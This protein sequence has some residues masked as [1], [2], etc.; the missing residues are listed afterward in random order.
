MPLPITFGAASARGFGLFTPVGG[1]GPA[2]WMGVVSNST[3]FIEARSV[4][5]DSVGNIYIVGT[6]QVTAFYYQLIKLNKF[7]VIQWQKRLGATSTTCFNYGM[8]LDPSN[9]VYVCGYITSSNTDVGVAKYNGSGVLQWQVGLTGGAIGY[10]IAYNTSNATLYCCGIAGSFAL[11]FQINTSGTVLWSKRYGNTSGGATFYFKGVAASAT[12][13]SNAVG[14]Y[15]SAP[16]NYITFIQTDS[17]G[18]SQWTN[19]SVRQNND[20]AYA[21]TLDG[22]SNLYI[23]GYSRYLSDDIY[24][25]KCNS[26]GALQWSKILASPSFQNGYGQGIATDSSNNVYVIGYSSSILVLAKYDS[27]G[28]L[29]WQRTITQSS[30]TTIGYG[31]KIDSSGDIC[32]CGSVTP[33]STN[34]MFIARLPADGSGVGTYTIGGYS[35]TYAASSYADTAI[36]VSSGPISLPDS[37]SGLTAYTP[38]LTDTATTGTA[39][40]TPL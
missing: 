13:T 3:N 36:S 37:A 2:Y 33:S 28:N 20:Q 31:I 35:Y 16:T 38:T 32:I 4:T 24:V 9:N 34:H 17:S 14:Y 25:A 15:T 5:T 19:Y 27:S 10:S 29:Q 8:A 22:S 12:G 7:G 40:I 26:S 1:G 18:N 39:V 11:L 6:I 30:G 23:T 21:V